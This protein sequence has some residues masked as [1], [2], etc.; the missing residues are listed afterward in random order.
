MPT[1]HPMLPVYALALSAFIFNTSEFIPV[2]LLSA[3][4]TDFAMKSEEVGIMM[5]VYA[6]LVAILSLPLMLLTA[7][8]ERKKLLIGVFALFIIAHLVAFFANSFDILLISRILVAI[9]HAC[10]WSITA[11]LVVRIAPDGK[12][13]QALGLLATGGA[14]AMIAGLPLG[15]IV[16]QISTWQTAF[17]GIGLIGLGV[18]LVLQKTLPTLPATQTGNLSSLPIIAKNKQL[19]MRYLLILL[20]VTA[21]FTAYSY[22]E[23]FVLH[24]GFSPNLATAVLLLFGVAGIISS[25]IFGKFFEKLQHKLMWTAFFIMASCLA[26]L[27]AV[28]SYALVWIAVALLWGGCGNLLG[29][30]LQMQI[31]KQTENDKD[32]A[33]SLFSAIFNVGIGAGAMIGGMVVAN[34]GLPFVGWAGSCLTLMAILVFFVAQ[35]TPNRRMP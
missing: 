27:W 19:L 16:G 3:I 23:P 29:L 4:G 17:L 30:S 21:H 31:L 12:G 5:T 22:I 15:R 11:S 13:S 9:A 35:S 24:A 20:V 10:F 18:V 33:M 8:I 26:L 7:N 2:A 1:T 14:V 34:V 6:W 25:L 32:V 28:K